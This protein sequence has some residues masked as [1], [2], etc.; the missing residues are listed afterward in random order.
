[1]KSSSAAP[2]P[3]VTPQSC[4]SI[5]SSST[6]TVQQ[7]PAGF[8]WNAASAPQPQHC[9]NQD[10]YSSPCMLTEAMLLGSYHNAIADDDNNKK[11]KND[12]GQVKA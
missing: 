9:G 5:D 1:M 11:K 4:N 7:A 6:I 2:K 3:G 8:C 10:V 12:N